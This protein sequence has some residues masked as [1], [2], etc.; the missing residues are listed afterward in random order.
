[1]PATLDNFMRTFPDTWAAYDR[2]RE[3]CDGEG[4]LDAKT[5]ELIKIGIATALGHDGSVIAHLARA[6][7]A[8]AS[9]A[10]VQ[11]AML[12]AITL[13]GF[14]AVLR[15]TEAARKYLEG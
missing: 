6:R 10:E 8:G 12:S 13:G 14:P 15:A 4:P 9:E 3:V 7:K 2:L 11:Q 1:M 5:I